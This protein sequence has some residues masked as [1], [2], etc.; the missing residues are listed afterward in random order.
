MLAVW[1]CQICKRKRQQ[2]HNYPWLHK[3]GRAFD[4]LVTEKN[5]WNWKFTLQMNV[6]FKSTQMELKI[7][8]SNGCFFQINKRQMFCPFGYSSVVSSTFW[9]FFCMLCLAK[10]IPERVQF[11]YFSWQSRLSSHHQAGWLFSF[12]GW[13]C[14]AYQCSATL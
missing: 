5:G 2:L 1:K 4:A 12:S 13:V 3:Q 9:L 8:T 10:T 7:H 11:L 14:K 6:F